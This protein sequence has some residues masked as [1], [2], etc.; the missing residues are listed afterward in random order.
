MARFGVLAS[1]LGLLESVRWAHGSVWFSDWISGRIHRLDPES[2]ELETVATVESL[3]LCFDFVGDELVVLDGAHDQVLRGPVGGPLEQWADTKS[4]AGGA[5][6]EVLVAGDD[7]FLN[8][9]NFNPR[10]GF[11]SSPVG[12]LARIRGDGSSSV[13]AEALAFPNGM[14][15]TPDGGAV[16]VA[17]S[18]A[19]RLS[20]WDFGADGT[21]G[22]RRDWAQLD[23]AAPDGISM[24]PD[25]TCWFADVSTSS[26][27]GVREGGEVVAQIP[28]DRGGFSCAVAPELGTIFVAAAHWPG[29]QGFGDP[30]HKWDGQILSF[31][32]PTN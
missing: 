18:Y 11:P 6:N 29:A 15:F 26:V 7:V 14:A 30:N 23:H 13:L 5:G 31:P 32:L 16:I 2:G 3:P 22:A 8:F 9:G 20:A 12:V 1:G 25:G 17:E 4:L 10:N 27:T 28:L 21:L 24:A 19:S